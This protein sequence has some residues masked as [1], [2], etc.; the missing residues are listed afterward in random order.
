MLFGIGYDIHRLVENRRLIL[1]GVVFDYHLGLLGHSDADV[2]IHA[3][4]DALLG[5]AALGDIGEHFPDTDV[6]WKDVSSSVLLLKVVHLLQESNF[7]INNVDVIILA[8]KPKI[9]VRKQEIRKN[10]AQLLCLDVNR[11]NIKAT[12]MEGVDAIGRGEAI[13]AQSIASLHE[14]T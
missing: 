3:I 12:T 4:C 1:G 6:R 5:A 9:G 7:K 10:I 11:V 13:A 14:N 8:Q 2:V